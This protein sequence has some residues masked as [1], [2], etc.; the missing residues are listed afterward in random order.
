MGGS[1]LPSRHALSRLLHV[2]RRHHDWMHTHPTTARTLG[3]LLRR[4]DNPATFPVLTSNGRV[5]LGDDGTT[6]PVED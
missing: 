4:T 3:W 2:C 5:L 6:H 1:S